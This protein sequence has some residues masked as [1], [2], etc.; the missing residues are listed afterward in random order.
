MTVSL[1]ILEGYLSCRY[2]AYLRLSNE[3][4]M[5]SDYEA[6]LTTLRRELK[7]KGLEIFSINI[8]ILL[9]LPASAK[10]AAA[11]AEV[12]HSLPTAPSRSTAFAWISTYCGKSLGI[13]A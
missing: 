5:K 8:Q 6:A 1:E 2:K 3:V 12:T 4:G 7:S 9:P 13:L 11:W 10:R